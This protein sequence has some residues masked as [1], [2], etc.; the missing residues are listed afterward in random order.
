MSHKTEDIRS[1]ASTKKY[2]DNYDRVFKKGK[3]LFGDSIISRPEVQDAQNRLNK[4]LRKA[5]DKFL[6]KDLSCV[7]RKS[8]RKTHIHCTNDPNFGG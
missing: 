6:D 2:R 1:K 4:S 7:Q 8:S 5:I 3:S